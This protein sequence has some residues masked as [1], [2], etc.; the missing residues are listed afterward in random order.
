RPDALGRLAHYEVQEIIGYGG[1]GVVLKAFDERLERTVA[2]K[3]LAAPLAAEPAAREGFLR[4]ARAVAAI[5]DEHVIDIHA[6]DEDNGVPYL[7]M[8]YVAGGSLQARL[9]RSGPPAL[10]ETVRIGKEVAL[11]LAAAHAQGLVHR[12]VKPA[13]ILMEGDTGK[14]R[15]TDF[16]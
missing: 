3:V 7:V 6:V 12:D 14:V 4:E 9:D 1:M 5:R 8:G 16:G 11:G 2:V 10:E 13:N 15:L